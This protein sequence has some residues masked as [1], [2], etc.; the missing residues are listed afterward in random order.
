MEIKGSTIKAEH[1]RM[2]MKILQRITVFLLKKTIVAT[3][4]ILYHI[5][6]VICPKDQK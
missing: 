1:I 6:A 3:G 2:K 4:I 5:N